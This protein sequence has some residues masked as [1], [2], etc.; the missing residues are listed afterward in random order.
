MAHLKEVLK[1]SSVRFNTCLDTLYHSLSVACAG[2][3][4]DS[5]T[6]VR[7]ALL[8]SFYVVNR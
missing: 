1:M 6:A 5:V 4:A 3:D 2:D 7:N 8:K